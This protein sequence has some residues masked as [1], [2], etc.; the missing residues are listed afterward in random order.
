[1]DCV[2]CEKC[3]VNGKIQFQGTAVALK[4][5]FSTVEGKISSLKNNEII[6]IRKINKWICLI[7]NH[8]L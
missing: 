2:E 8:R 3:K 1:M 6:V 5:L 4:I 7:L